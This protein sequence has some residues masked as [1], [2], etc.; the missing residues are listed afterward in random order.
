MLRNL[1]SELR[2]L[3][4]QVRDVVDLEGGTATD[5]PRA[6]VWGEGGLWDLGFRV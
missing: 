2:H 1:L 3:C 5:E 6:A 4:P